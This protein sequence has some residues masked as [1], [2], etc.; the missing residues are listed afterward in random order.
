MRV[1]LEILR[2]ENKNKSLYWQKI[3]YETDD[4][5][6]TV[7]TAL[8][9]INNSGDYKDSENKPVSHICWECSCMQKRCGA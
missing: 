6:E 4:E 1:T 8:N 7:A 9:R 2:R 5:N 3:I